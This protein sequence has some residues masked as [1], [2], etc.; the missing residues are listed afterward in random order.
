MYLIGQ[1]P[2]LQPQVG[3]DVLVDRPGEFVVQL[4][5]DEAQQHRAEGDHAGRGDQAGIQVGP[6][7][8]VDVARHEQLVDRLVH[9]V[10]LHRRVD[11]HAQVVHADPDHLDGI[12]QPQRIPDEHQLVDK[13]KDENGEVGRDGQRPHGLGRRIGRARLP[14]QTRLELPEDIRL[15]TQAYNRLEQGDQGERPGPSRAGQVHLAATLPR[16]ARGAD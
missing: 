16:R 9:L 5:R 10:H 14:F 12:L 8:S 4:P 1:I 7:A 15:Q 6:R 2:L 13:P 11:H 3:G